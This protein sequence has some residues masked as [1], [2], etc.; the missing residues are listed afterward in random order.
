MSEPRRPRA[1]SVNAEE[2][3]PSTK[4]AKTAT[5]NREPRSVKPP[6]D[7]KYNDVDETFFAAQEQ[8]ELDAIDPASVQ[9]TPPRRSFLY[10]F[11][12]I[13]LGFLITASLGLWLE[14]L[15]NDLMAQ[16]I[17]LGR[18]ALIAT[19]IFAFAVLIFVLR[20]VYS[21]WKLR[22]I[23]KLRQR[24]TQALALNNANEIKAVT[25]ELESHF[26]QNPKTALG[27]KV[28]ELNR[29]DILDATD[30]YAL[31]ERELLK[32]LDREAKQIVMGAAKRV[33]VVTA[34]SPRALIDIGYVLFENVRL[35]RVLS[36]HYGGRSGFLS[37]FSLI[38]KVIAHLAVTGTI[39]IGDGLMQQMLGHGLAAKLSARLGE[40]VINGIM[41]ARVGLSAIN[42]CRPAPFHALPAPK[43]SQI[44]SNLLRQPTEK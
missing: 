5:K 9:P 27:R 12:T 32:G 7:L 22:S 30:R 38:R 44:A 34:V 2:T 15:V 25:H 36:Q 3:K 41:T 21:I 18:T 1:F 4:G 14:G 28:L 24:I 11:A 16:N 43:L 29:E 35:I 40:G 33:S 26:E 23:S 37:T 8:D 19:A 42:I 20:E 39:A 10:N 31:T 6:A 17:W 13:A